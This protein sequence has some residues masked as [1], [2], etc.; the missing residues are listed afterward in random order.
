[1]EVLVA[2][3]VEITIGYHLCF[4]IRSLHSEQQGVLL[5]NSPAFL[6]GTSWQD[7]ICTVKACVPLYPSLE[8]VWHTP[9]LQPVLNTVLIMMMS[10]VMII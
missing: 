5:K 10:I 8:K 6:L 2:T 9:Y 4:T 7:F 1:M 3:K